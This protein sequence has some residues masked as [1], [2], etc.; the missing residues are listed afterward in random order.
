MRALIAGLRWLWDNLDPMLA[1]G[2][3]VVFAVLGAYGV[4]T[5]PVISN[6]V[7]ATLAVIAF[8][9]VRER[10]ARSG[11]FADVERSLENRLRNVDSSI[12]Q[13][14]EAVKMI[15]TLIKPTQGRFLTHDFEQAIQ[16]TRLWIY[17]GGTGT[18]LRAVTLP[19]NAE[20]AL[21]QRTRRE[22]SIEILDPTNV[23]LCDQYGRMRRSLDPKP[24]RSG[25]TWTTIRVRKE[26][27]ATILA[28][29]Y[30]RESHGLLDIQLGLSATMSLF[31][32]DLASPYIIIIQEDGT[33]PA[34][35]AS[36]GTYFYNSYLN[37]LRLSFDQSRKLDLERANGIS[38]S[39][40]AEIS[41]REVSRLFQALG[42]PLDDAFHENEIRS[43]IQKAFNPV[44]LY[45]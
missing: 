40:G 43:M 15:D 41:T 35:E 11:T 23:E 32:Y 25:E 21:R 37:E 34:L 26:S 36:S 4:A 1:L 3:A 31:R 44:N 6:V 39:A 13:V 33:A 5:Q 20:N 24:D 16:S 30:Y 7:L 8:T 9:L 17:K 38:L 42:V 22:I 10:A 19:G 12:A 18:Y 45:A 29:A 2:L 14:R 27:Y 28:A